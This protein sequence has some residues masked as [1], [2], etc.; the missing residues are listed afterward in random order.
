MWHANRYDY[1]KSYTRTNT[2]ANNNNNN[3]NTSI[4][5]CVSPFVCITRF[6]ILLRLYVVVICMVFMCT[7]LYNRHLLSL[8]FAR[9]LTVL[10]IWFHTHTH[11]CSRSPWLWSCIGEWEWET[12]ILLSTHSL[13]LW[14][15]L[16]KSFRSRILSTERKRNGFENECWNVLTNTHATPL[17]Y[18]QF[19][20]FALSGCATH[21]KHCMC[22][23]LSENFSKFQFNF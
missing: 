21:R 22:V 6:F 13:S 15:A 2:H 12:Y 1:S 11:T 3:N 17:Y 14:F 16:L 9:T 5:V 23:T 18:T 8:S 10:P 4:A 7:L 20:L 19:L